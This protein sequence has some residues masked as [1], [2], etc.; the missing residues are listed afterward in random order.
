MALIHLA[1]AAAAFLSLIAPIAAQ[2]YY[3]PS[4]SVTSTHDGPLTSSTTKPATCASS[5]TKYSVLTSL[6]IKTVSFVTTVVTTVVK[7]T[8]AVTTVPVLQTQTV[9]SCVAAPST[10]S[11]SVVTCAT[12]IPIVIGSYTSCGMFRARKFLTDATF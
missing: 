9:V 3:G 4:S 6:D 10:S 2:G 12:G 1:L 7:T 8:S 11:S 5:V